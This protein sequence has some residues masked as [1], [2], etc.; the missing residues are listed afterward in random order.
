MSAS[1]PS[2][3]LNLDIYLG[4][5]VTIVALGSVFVAV[6]CVSG[7]SQRKKLLVDDY[8]S[9]LALLL[10]A[11]ILAV[12]YNVDK[13]FDKPDTS[14]LWI[15]RVVIAVNIVTPFLTWSARAPI[16]FLYIN[17]FGVKTWLRWSSIITLIVT[18]LLCF[19]AMVVA[20]SECKP[21]N[22][23]PTGLPV[24]IQY[25]TYSGLIT[26]FV[27]VFVDIVVFLLP[28]PVIL[29]LQLPMSKRIGLGVVFSSGILAIVASLVG[30]VYKWESW[31]GR[32]GYL[33]AEFTLL[34]E[35]GAA[36]II[37]CVPAVN[38]FSSTYIGKRR[39]FSKTQPKSYGN[40]S[41]KH[42][43]EAII[44]RSGGDTEHSK[45]YNQGNESYGLSSIP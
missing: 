25:S 38:F 39:L 27:S 36:I 18:G 29:R 4:V 24:C 5:G 28:I 41:W 19:S 9:I 14:P 13:G 42:S 2:D 20:L 33:P 21:S 26:G 37:G 6:R 22:G 11:A 30:L 15:V 35:T 8:I 23:T 43:Q 31:K 40:S 44:R 45:K 10:L 17:L 7:L 32:A 34:F 1:A 3:G 16:L 12:N